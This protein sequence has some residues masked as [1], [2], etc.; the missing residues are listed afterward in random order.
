MEDYYRYR[1]EN[2]RLASGFMIY[3]YNPVSYTH[4]FIVVIKIY[5]YKIV[6]KVNKRRGIQIYVSENTAI[7]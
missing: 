7:I 2:G 1:E 6:L 5:I 4:L 3:T